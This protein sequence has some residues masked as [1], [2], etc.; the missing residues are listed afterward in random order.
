V[1]D[2]DILGPWYHGSQLVLD[3]LRPG[4]S[5]TRNPIIARAFS[6]RPSLLSHPGEG[7][8]N[9]NGTTPGYLYIVAEEIQPNDVYPHPH[10]VN[11]GAW[12]WITTRELRIRLLERTEPRDDE[13]LTEGEIA[14]L[15]RKQEASAGQ[16]FAIES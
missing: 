16:S 7:T 6:H 4:S 12:E 14:D 9:H 2:Q 5:I 15:R 8:V 10:P 13:R 11:V 1:S 3:T